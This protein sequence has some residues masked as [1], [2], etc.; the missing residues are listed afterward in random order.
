M[1]R[2]PLCDL[3]GIDIPII[4]APASPYTTPELVSAVS[5]AG[6]L[7]SYSTALRSFEQIER[8][9]SRIRELTDRPFA[10]N[11]LMRSFDPEVFEHVL[12]EP[13]RVISFAAGIPD[14]LIRRAHGIGA[15]ILVQVTTVDQA[16]TAVA[17]DVDVIVAQ[18][19]EAGGLTGIVSL[20]P[21]LPQVVDAVN[22][23]PVVAAGGIADGRGVAAALV[24][25]AQGVNI[26]TRFL[27]SDE[28]LSDDARRM[29]LTRARS[30]DTVRAS[31]I[32]RLFPP[33]PD[34]LPLTMRSLRTP[35]LDEWEGRGDI[36]EEELEALREEMIAAIETGRMHEYAAG[37]GE[38][39]GLI[40]DI[41][42]AAVIL[43]RLVTEA[44]MT[45]RT[46]ASLVEPATP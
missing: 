14:Q 42:P 34:T 16:L 7:G 21:L 17:S 9:L 12:H 35:F 41:A 10:V 26:G 36:G 19:T 43:N 30:E 39:V 44:E 45:L 2:T 6:G 37:A 46:A 13:P 4:Q 38:S 28:A 11:F 29:A 23:R 32:D 1:L 33:E 22:P 15:V 18:G 20:M 3:L 25:G 8:D 5:N 27:A 31:I 40:H 24:L